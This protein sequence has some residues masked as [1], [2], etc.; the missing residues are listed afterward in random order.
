MSSMGRKVR[1]WLYAA[2]GCLLSATLAQAQTD[3]SGSDVMQVF[4]S[5]GSGQQQQI[6]QQLGV[7]GGTPSGQGGINQSERAGQE[8]DLEAQ[9]LREQRREQQELEERFPILRPQDWV[10]IEVDTAPLAPR[11]ADTTEALYRALITG[12]LGHAR[13]PRG[14]ARSQLRPLRP[15]HPSSPRL[16]CSSCSNCKAGQGQTGQQNP[17]SQANG[18]ISVEQQLQQPYSVG[19]QAGPPNLL[20]PP[21][22]QRLAQLVALIR[23]K[24]PYQ[25]TRDGV[26]NLPGF[27]GIAL[28]G[29]TE[30][31]ATLRLEVEPALRG[32]Y[33][34][35]T[36]LPLTKT[37]VAGTRAVRLRHL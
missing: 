37:G 21:D 24:D 8:A 9:R 1:P 10:V 32:L 23:S 5:M 14:F 6:L 35:V 7:G 22:P 28:A 25:L 12:T 18:S 19:W 17:S 4:R 31:Q 11:P 34:R 33:F 30:A 2:L 13:C 3:T 16:S 26:V 29:L 20:S 15:S 27:A 36:K